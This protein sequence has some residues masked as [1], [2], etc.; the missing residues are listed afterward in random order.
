MLL[1]PLQKSEPNLRQGFAYP[2]LLCPDFWQG[3]A[4]PATVS[5]ESQACFC[6]PCIALFQIALPSLAIATCLRWQR[7]NIQ[8]AV[9]E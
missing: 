9:F 3:F 4:T 6:H 5:T 8:N 7:Y 2:A 1:Q